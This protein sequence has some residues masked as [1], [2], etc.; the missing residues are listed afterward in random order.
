[1]TSPPP[2]YYSPQAY[3][4][5]GPKHCIIEGDHILIICAGYFAVNLWRGECLWI[6]PVALHRPVNTKNKTFFFFLNKILFGLQNVE[7][8]SLHTLCKLFNSRFHPEKQKLK[9]NKVLN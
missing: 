2:S 5:G 4:L 6:M 3:Q 1:M 9:L 7:I 8:K